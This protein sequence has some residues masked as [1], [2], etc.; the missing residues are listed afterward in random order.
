MRVRAVV[1]DFD[2]TITT[3]QGGLSNPEL[4]AELKQVQ[5][6]VAEMA[7]ELEQARAKT[8]D[9]PCYTEAEAAAVL[10]LSPRQ[11]A[12]ERRRGAVPPHARTHGTNSTNRTPGGTMPSGVVVSWRARSAKTA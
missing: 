5:A 4:I 11:L 3:D 6:I 8:P 10:K 1:V 9:K 12:D 2:G 7:A